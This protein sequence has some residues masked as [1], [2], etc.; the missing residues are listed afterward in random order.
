[1]GWF[2]SEKNN[3]PSKVLK[4][5]STPALIFNM[6]EW[7]EASP[8][9]GCPIRTRFLQN[10]Y[11]NIGYNYKVVYFIKKLERGTRASKLVL[12]VKNL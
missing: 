6:D 2:L 5:E 1:M 3:S 4:M 8:R 10:I 12:L 11:H 9:K 7:Q